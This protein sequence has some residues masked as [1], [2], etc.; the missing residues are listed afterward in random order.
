ML[1]T[2]EPW[3]VSCFPR[4]LDLPLRTDG[5]MEGFTNVRVS[6]GHTVGSQ[7]LEVARSR[8]IVNVFIENAETL[9]SANQSTA[10]VVSVFSKLT[11]PSLELHMSRTTGSHPVQAE[12]NFHEGAICL[13]TL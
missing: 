13:I 4:G 7:R 12:C 5:V 2:L 1:A 11:R 6:S 8:I 10:T 3:R 9:L